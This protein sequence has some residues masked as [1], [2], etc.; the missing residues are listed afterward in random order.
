MSVDIGT[1]ADPDTIA[2]GRT[3]SAFV[4]TAGACT[5]D[6][7]GAA[8][9]TSSSHYVFRAGAGGGSD[10]GGQATDGQMELTGVQDAVHATSIL[11]TV[12]P[13]SY[14][15]WASVVEA[16]GGTNR[17]FSESLLNKTI[18]EAESRSGTQVDLLVG[19]PKVNNTIAAQFSPSRR[20][21]D[22]VELKAGWTGLAYSTPLEGMQG[23][24]QRA[25]VGDHDCPEYALFGLASPT[26]K[27]YQTHDWKFVDED[28]SPMW[29]S[30]DRDD[31]YE[32]WLRIRD[33]I[34]YTQRSANFRISD[35]EQA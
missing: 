13:S 9:T 17:A 8:V 3:T 29:R 6:I 14:P 24:A 26:I 11:H 4:T 22:T 19:N 21:N 16:N 18:A 28:G 25:L 35:L 30:P 10:N 7:S 32:V 2:A 23:T 12:N 27:R 33:E 1:V 5:F 20:Y 31:S 15:M 34:A